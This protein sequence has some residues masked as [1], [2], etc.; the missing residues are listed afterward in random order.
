[1]LSGPG[2]STGRTTIAQ[3]N[4]GCKRESLPLF[5][6][7]FSAFVC[8]WLLDE[9]IGNFRPNPF[10]FG[11]I[12]VAKG[13]CMR[14][15][16]VMALPTHTC[17][18]CPVPMFCCTACEPFSL[19][20][21]SAEAKTWSSPVRNGALERGSTGLSRKRERNIINSSPSVHV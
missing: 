17:A 3:C 5:P 16:H 20:D 12:R 15:G 19:M 21:P 8:C 11:Y 9:F 6:P 18:V 13:E 2:G 1:M 10:E 7:L 4:E 14:G